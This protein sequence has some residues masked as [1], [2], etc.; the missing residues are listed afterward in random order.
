MTEHK[1]IAPNV[2]QA[3]SYE[4]GGYTLRADKEKGW[5]IEGLDGDGA[6]SIT[7]PTSNEAERAIKD[8]TIER[9]DEYVVIRDIYK[10]AGQ[11]ADVFKHVVRVRALCRRFVIAAEGYGLHFD[12]ELLL[13]AAGLHD[14]GK[15]DDYE[16]DNHHKKWAVIDVLEDYGASEQ[17]TAMWEGLGVFQVIKAH[18]KDFSPKGHALEAAVLRICDKLDKIDKA[19][20]KSKKES[21][22]KFSKAMFSCSKTMEKIRE[23]LSEEQFVPLSQA[24]IQLLQSQINAFA[25]YIQRI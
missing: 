19:R 15:D 18:R 20:K 9:F 16:E 3:V 22:K 17:Q 24:Y 8:G 4:R 12:T 13:F 7:Y 25:S 10:K 23:E 11:D 14:I 1:E 21:L 6:R 5:Y 2:F